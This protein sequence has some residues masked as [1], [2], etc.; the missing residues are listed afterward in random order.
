MD[1]SH[2]KKKKKRPLTKQD[3][4]ELVRRHG[5]SCEEL[6]SPA[7]VPYLAPPNSP[8]AELLSFEQEM[9]LAD[10]IA[11]IQQPPQPPPPPPASPEPP[12]P[13]PPLLTPVCGPQ[14]SWV[15]SLFMCHACFFENTN[16]V[17]ASPGGRVYITLSLCPRCARVNSEVNSVIQKN[18]L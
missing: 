12:P 5:I 11:S 10:A 14:L 16:N 9:E 7:P 15:G 8:C 17:M 3:L 4:L 18:Q 6:E 1:P 2:E 13:P